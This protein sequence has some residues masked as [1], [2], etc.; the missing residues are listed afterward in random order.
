MLHN[1]KHWGWVAINGKKNNYLEFG[2]G[3]K[4]LG[5]AQDSAKVVDDFFRQIE[6]MLKTKKE[7]GGLDGFS[8]GNKTTLVDC[9]LINCAQSFKLIIGLNIPKRYP[10]VWMSS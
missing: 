7:R 3:K 9:A 2:H 5:W 8:V 6:D 10:L 1:L 4:D